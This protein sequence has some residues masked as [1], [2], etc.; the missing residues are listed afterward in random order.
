MRPTDKRRIAKDC[1]DAFWD[2]GSKRTVGIFPIVKLVLWGRI[3]VIRAGEQ[4]SIVISLMF[5]I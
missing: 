4:G 2:E 1:I 5:W 3:V